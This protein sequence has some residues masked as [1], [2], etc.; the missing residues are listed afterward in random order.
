MNNQ[1]FTTMKKVSFAIVMLLICLSIKAQSSDNLAKVNRINGVPVYVM[2]QP[3]TDYTVVFMK[4]TGAKLGALAS[5]GTVNEGISAKVGQ[6]VTRISREARKTNQE[7]DAILYLEGKKA[8]AIK[9]KSPPTPEEKDLAKVNVVKGIK[10]YVM[11]EPIDEYEVINDKSGGAK[12][13]S[14]FTGGIVN[15]TISGDVGQFAKRIK[16]S[17]KKNNQVIDAMIYN[18]GKR[19]VGIKLK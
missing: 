7:F 11:N 1:L 12:A 6:F 14:Y 8:A 2:C 5:E 10:V 16:R 15:R 13:G 3:V 19:A 9:F 17:S 4:N 18:V